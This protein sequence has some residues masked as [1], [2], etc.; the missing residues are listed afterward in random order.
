MSAVVEALRKRLR[1]VHQSADRGTSLMELVVG[2]AIMSICGALFVGSVVG[3]NR[4]TAKAQSATNAATQ[5]NQAF[6]VLDKTVR[7]AAAITT[8]G[9]GT[10][11]N[12]YVELRDTTSGSETCIQLRLDISSQQL[13][14]R[15]WSAANP[16]GVTAFLPIASGLTNGAATAGSADQPF[17]LTAL[18]ATANHQQLTVNLTARSG[19]PPSVTSSKSSFTLTA[20]N[21]TIP[22][23]TGSV[24]KQVARP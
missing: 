7:Y 11:G 23:P 16:A 1:A 2:M 9:K 21:S 24:C 13:Q 8:P 17:V 4:S 18:G 3:L 19:N 20:I 15:T 12:W 22:P 14:K 5:T 10:S 6:L